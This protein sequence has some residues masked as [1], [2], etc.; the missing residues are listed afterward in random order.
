MAHP[1]LEFSSNETIF[2][3]PGVIV[4]NG[5]DNELTFRNFKL[6]TIKPLEFKFS[7]CGKKTHKN[8][9]HYT[10]DG[11]LGHWPRDGFCTALPRYTADVLFMEYSVL[12]K[13]K[14][15]ESMIVVDSRNAGLMFNVVDENNY[16][17]VYIR[18]VYLN[19]YRDNQ[20]F[21]SREKT[22]SLGDQLLDVK[23]LAPFF[24]IPF[25]FHIGLASCLHGNAPIRHASYR[26][27][28][29]K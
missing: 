18:F 11:L 4:S 15:I 3:F 1:L 28:V 24:T 10:M 14:I 27:R 20:R 17:Y 12:V 2:S 6:K 26:F 21:C 22:W 8:N 29:F 23:F 25:S 13:F 5:G 7:N 16:E 19:T 9:G